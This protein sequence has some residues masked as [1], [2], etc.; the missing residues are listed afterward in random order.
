MVSYVWGFG[1]L[2]LIHKLYHFRSLTPRFVGFRVLGAMGWKALIKLKSKIKMEHNFFV[3]RK[4]YCKLIQNIDK[5]VNIVIKTK[6]D[7]C[8]G[9]NQDHSVCYRSIILQI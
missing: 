9:F 1:V 6:S 2:G 5:Q 4:Y 3:L 8:F 7:C